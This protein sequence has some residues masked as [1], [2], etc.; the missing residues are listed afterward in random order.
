M[1]HIEIRFSFISGF[2]CCVLLS[3]CGFYVTVL[4]RKTEKQRT[5]PRGP[6]ALHLYM[7]SP[8]MRR[9]SKTKEKQTHMKHIFNLLTE[10]L[11]CTP[12]EMPAHLL[13]TWYSTALFHTFSVF[14]DWDVIYLRSWLDIFCKTYLKIHFKRM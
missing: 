7:S 13:H 10:T 6:P 11:P 4:Q 5:G 3:F 1:L 14:P 8:Y 9:S 12:Q 2:P